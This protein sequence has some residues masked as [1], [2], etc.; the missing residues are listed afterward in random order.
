MENLCRPCGDGTHPALILHTAWLLNRTTRAAP[1]RPGRPRPNPPP[2]PVG[3][4]T[5]P[6]EH[7]PH[8]RITEPGSRLDIHQRHRPATSA[9]RRSGTCRHGRP[10]SPGQPEWL[11]RDPYHVLVMIGEHHPGQLQ[12]PPA[13]PSPTTSTSPNSDACPYT[14]GTHAPAAPPPHPQPPRAPA[15]YRRTGRQRAGT[16]AGPVLPGSRSRRTYDDAVTGHMTMLSLVS[17]Q[18][19]RGSRPTS[20]HG[21]VA[22]DK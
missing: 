16:S 22:N 1:P 20:S 5:R 10:I 15:W 12:P 6:R 2:P 11:R 7:C 4:L 9:S 3:H 18:V 13:G 14:S 8:R 19:A 17:N 21:S